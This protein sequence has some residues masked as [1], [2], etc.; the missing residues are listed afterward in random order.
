MLEI[1]FVISVRHLICNA[2]SLGGPFM[3][4]KM[5]INF[6]IPAFKGKL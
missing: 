1:S 4:Q 6:L 3:D 2:W 5:S